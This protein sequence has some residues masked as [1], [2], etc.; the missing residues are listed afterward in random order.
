[1]D[2]STFSMVV[3]TFADVFPNSVLVNTLGTDFLAIGYKGGKCL[4]LSNA[5]RNF[6]FAQKSR[7][8][9]LLNPK[10]LYG[11]VVTEDV[12]G[13]CGPGE[14]NTDAWPRL[15]FAAPKIMF[16]DDSTIKKNI[17]VR[18][19]LRPETLTVLRELS[20]DVN[21]Q[22]DFAALVF[23]LNNPMTSMIDFAKAT[24]QQMQR[25]VRMVTDYCASHIMDYSILQD[26]TLKQECCSVQIKAIEDKLDTL[27]DKASAYF[28]LGNLYRGNQLFADA[29]KNYYKAL[30]L[31]LSH[32]SLYNNL[33]VV[34][35]MQGKLDEA[36]TYYNKA[37]QADPNLAGAQYNLNNAMI[38]RR[39][40]FIEPNN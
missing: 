12:G 29:E 7:N 35:H 6:Q 38:Q 17:N 8:M 26:E 27:E 4:K 15:E 14:I 25:C 13:L 9:A 21:A 3:R 39:K 20:S 40:L 11:L 16:V 30:E 18:R 1:M 5:E 10:S 24:P 34:L 2:W 32:A 33:A 37:L 23:S 22:I 31:K 36:I 28:T 19:S